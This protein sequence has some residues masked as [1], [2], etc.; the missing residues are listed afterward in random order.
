MSRLK[1]DSDLIGVSS[2]LERLTGV[3]V[4]DVFQEDDTLYVIVN[5]G[6]LGRAVGKGGVGI[7]RVQEQLHKKIRVIEHRDVLAEFVKN[8]IYPVTVQEIVEEDDSVV[9]K[10]SNRKTKSIIIGREGKN[11]NVIKR[12]VQRFFPGKDVKVV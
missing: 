2:I 10:D 8:I 5:P 7:K 6:D 11:L 12:A 3:A 4:K 1:L 9:I